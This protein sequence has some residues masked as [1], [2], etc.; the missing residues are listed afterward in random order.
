MLQFATAAFEKTEEPLM[1]SIP[2]RHDDSGLVAVSR[3]PLSYETDD[4]RLHGHQ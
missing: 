2:R 3:L 1:H 4:C